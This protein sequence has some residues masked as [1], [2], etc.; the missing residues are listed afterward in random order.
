MSS[1]KQQSRG[2][3]VLPLGY[4]ILL[5]CQRRLALAPTGHCQGLDA[6]TKCA[7]ALLAAPA[8]EDC[9]WHL[10][11]RRSCRESGHSYREVTWPQGG[12][13]G[14]PA[15]GNSWVCQAQSTIYKLWRGSMARSERS[16][17]PK[18]CQS[19]FHCNRVCSVRN[20]RRTPGGGPGQNWQQDLPL[21]VSAKYGWAS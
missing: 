8:P 2:V 20:C 21:S 19:A 5:L 12:D 9:Y 13:P 17:S 11:S 1:V 6:C 3:A 4:L 14:M 10:S 16:R 15:S 7:N 18:R